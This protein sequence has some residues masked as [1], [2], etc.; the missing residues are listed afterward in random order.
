MSRYSL[1]TKHSEIFEYWKDKAITKCGEVIIDDY[2]DENSIS[3]VYDRGEPCCWACGEFIKDTYKAKEYEECL[4]QNVKLIYDIPKIRSKYNRCHIIPHSAG[5]S[6]EPSNLFLLCENCHE[7]SPDTLNPTNFF[8]WVY[9]KRKSGTYIDGTNMTEFLNK[10]IGI[11]KQKG[12]NPYT[13][14]VKEATKRAYT[15]GMRV[16]ESTKYMT[17]ADTCDNL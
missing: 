12:K 13:F 8:L 3:V 16:S 11:C 14:D 4:K 6:N 17:L 10:F 2:S 15:H 5:G 9:N 1:N 7:E